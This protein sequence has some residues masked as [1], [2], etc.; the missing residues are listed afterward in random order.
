MSTGTADEQVSQLYAASYMRLVAVVGAV[1]RDRHDA[2]EAVQDA[3]A[4]LLGQWQRVCRYDD[5]EAW[6]LKVALGFAS[7]RRRKTLNGL[8]AAGRH[9]PPAHAPAPTGD[10]VDL[11]RA[12]A[13]LPRAQREV[14]LLQHV[15]LSI[16]EIARDLGI[17]EGTVKSRL[18]RARAA[19]TPLLREYADTHV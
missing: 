18:A 16:P 5:P 10:A 15:G 11:H 13:T 7:N 17:A 6:V 9:G 4:R 14:L 3:F 2:E 8:R 1:H 19:L 12:L